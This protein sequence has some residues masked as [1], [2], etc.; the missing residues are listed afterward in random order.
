MTF[1]AQAYFCVFYRIFNAPRIF[2]Q[3]L[4]YETT[5][6]LVKASFSAMGHVHN[7]VVQAAPLLTSMHS[8]SGYNISQKLECCQER[9][10]LCVSFLQFIKR[11]IYLDTQHAGLQIYVARG[12]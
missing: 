9:Q 8:V 11:F 4:T 2:H 10:C 12:L 6:L 7:H 3:N 1:T 5:M